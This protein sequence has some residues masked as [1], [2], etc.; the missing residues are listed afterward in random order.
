MNKLAIND[1]QFL[2]L[3]IVAKCLVCFYEI[4]NASVWFEPKI[5]IGSILKNTILFH[6][7]DFFVCSSGCTNFRQDDGLELLCR[8]IIADDSDFNILD[9]C[10]KA[11]LVILEDTRW[12]LKC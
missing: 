9:S 8:L 12:G 10:G 2:K 4:F 3:A 11:F 7:D 5:V 1:N 6:I